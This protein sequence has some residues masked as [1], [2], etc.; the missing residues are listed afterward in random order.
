MTTAHR[1]EHQPRDDVLAALLAPWLP[2]RRWFPVKG[3]DARVTAVGGLTLVDP[4]GEAE[5]RVLLVRVTSAG[6]TSAS[7]AAAAATSPAD[8]TTGTAGSGTAGSGT[9]AGDPSVVLQV[10]L[11]LRPTVPAARL[12]GVEPPADQAGTVIPPP[13]DPVGTLADGTRVLDG[14]G[15]PAFLRAWLAAADSDR[16]TRPGLPSAGAPG[17]RTA[18]PRAIGS[19]TTWSGTTRPSTIEPRASGPSVTGASVHSPRAF[20]PDA[21]F[22]DARVLTGEQSNTSVVLPGAGPDGATAVLKVFRGLSDGANPDVDVPLALA[23]AGWP[24]VPRPLAWLTATWPTPLDRPDLPTVGNR[25]VD[26]DRAADED[27]ALARGHLGVLSVFVPAAHDGFELACASASSG[28]SFAVLSDELGRVIGQLHRALAAALPVP[29][30]APRTAGPV[31]EPAGAERPGPEP[32]GPLLSGSVPAATVARA[33]TDRFAWA[34]AAVPELRTYAPA[35]TRLSERTAG[36]VALP[37][38]QRV[39]GD[40]HLG[41]VLHGE[42]SWYVLDFEG[43]PLLPVARRTRPD[44]ALRDV[45]GMLRSFDY[46]AAVGGADETWAADARAAFLHG[47]TAESPPIDLELRDHLLQVLELDKALYEAVY[48]S[49]NRPAWTAIP[50]AAVARLLR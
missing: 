42:R 48:E 37:P 49:R 40:L 39:H 44:L 26:A 47:Y 43:E 45:A 15:H 19:G 25:P 28:A 7:S 32:S 1:V 35:V 5:V 27:A 50:L 3:A 41:Q 31:P 18:P 9:A 8:T 38:R 12:G 11:V 24:H 34:A 16:T 23:R 30:D 14:V 46:A 2:A 4:R 36:L 20:D 22:E 13:L 17:P 10:P 6:S 33:L 29:T 21:S